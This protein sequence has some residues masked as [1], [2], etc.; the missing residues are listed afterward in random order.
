ML[1]IFCAR[2]FFVVWSILLMVRSVTAS[3][4]PEVDRVIAIQTCPHSNSRTYKYDTF[5]AKA[6]AAMTKVMEYY[7]QDHI[8]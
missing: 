7:S 1:L 3:R 2:E 6:F 4:S 5:D 8:S